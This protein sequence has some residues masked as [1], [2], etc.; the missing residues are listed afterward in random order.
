MP[1][2]IRPDP[3]TEKEAWAWIEGHELPLERAVKIQRLLTNRLTKLGFGHVD[4]STDGRSGFRIVMDEGEAQFENAIEV[5]D[6]VI[7]II[8]GSK[9]RFVRNR[10]PY[11]GLDPWDYRFTLVEPLQG[12]FALN[13]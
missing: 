1:N 7:E 5:D 6:F 9:N 11:I 10:I 3:R 2:L 13:E 4:V 12:E 8:Q